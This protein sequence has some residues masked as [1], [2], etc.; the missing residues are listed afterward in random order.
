MGRILGVDYGE[1]RLGFALS[2]P[3]QTIAMPLKVVTVANDI[4]AAQEV[5]D[6][7]RE[8]KADSLVIGVPLNMNGSEGSSATKV[9]RFI[10]QLK[11]TLG[12]PVQ[13][14]DERL[15][16]RMVERMLV[17]ADVRRSRRKEV[18]DKLAAQVILQGYLDWRGHDAATL[19]DNHRV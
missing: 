16:T 8:T 11:E 14:W 2:D 7:C 13:P 12:I 1:R 3:G 17:G 5:S 4:E 9:R 6:T 19:Q 10:G 15:T 18:R